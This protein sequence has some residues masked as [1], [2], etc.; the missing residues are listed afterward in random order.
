MVTILAV[1]F[2][3]GLLIMGHELGHF[4]VAKLSG[5]KVNEFSFGMGPRI[6]KFGKGE[7][8]Y[9]WRLFPIGGFVKMLGEEEQVDDPR[10]FSMKPTPVKMG[11]IAAGPVMNIIISILIFGALAMAVGYMKPVVDGYYENPNHTD[12]VFPAKEKGI[13][14][15]DRII[16]VNGSRIYTYEDF[17][18]FV[19][20]NGEKTF[21]LTVLRQ[22]KQVDISNIKPVKDPDEGVYM[23]G[24][25][26][27]YGR[28]SLFE[29]LQY[30]VLST[31]SFAKQIVVVFR[32]LISG[33]ASTN[34]LSGPVG[35][36]KI[37]GDAAKQGF[38][39]LLIFTAFL[40]INLAIMNLIPF[41]ALDGGWLLI[42]LI[43]GIRRKKLD[44]NKIGIINFIGFAFL[45]TLMLLITF[46]DIT[47]LN[48]FR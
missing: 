37:A 33:R 35:I 28:A 47:R 31:W 45:M 12:I 38:D 30:G 16:K 25:V 6:L 14:K 26:S 9:S 8:E 21:D 11:I 4:T 19:Y 32:N 20:Q 39:S 2:V 13:Q 46:K 41:P 34:D 3:F 18:M 22:G 40:S 44:A 15:G 24:I 17:R 10:S 23:I 43:E 27:T 7:T 36:V 48:P 29:G 1:I 5:V 42:L